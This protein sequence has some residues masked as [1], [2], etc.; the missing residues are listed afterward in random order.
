MSKREFTAPN[1]Y[2][3]NHS[4]NVRWLISHL[5]R[6]KLMVVATMVAGVVMT[7]TYT[8]SPVLIGQAAEEVMNP[9][10]Q[11]GM[12]ALLILG[13]LVLSGL[14]DLFHA[15]TIETLAQRLETGVREELYASLLGKSQTFH[16][17]QRVGDIMARATD[18]AQQLNGMVNPGLYF[19]FTTILG[20]AIPLFHISQLRA[21]LLLVPTIFVIAYVIVLRRYMHQLKPVTF[22]QRMQFGKMN[23]VAEETISGIEI[24][25]ASA[26]E[27]FERRKF[28][29]NARLFRGYFVRQGFIE[30]RYLPLLLL[31]IAT[32]FALL[33]AVVLYNA[34]SIGIAEI[35]AYMGLINVLR[36]PT[37]ISVFSF[38][39]VQMGLAS[40]HR[41]LNIIQTETEMD[42]NSGGYSKPLEGAI[43]FENVT[44]AYDE[45][46]VLEDISFSIRPGQTVAIVGQTGSGKSTLTQLINRTYDVKSG[47][48]LIDGVDV[49]DWDLSGLRSQISNIEQDIF[50]FSRSLSENI[51]FGRPEATQE[52]IERVSSEAQAHD[53]IQSFAQGYATEVGDRGVTL[54]G[55]QRQRIA[56]AR[57][58]LSDPR[59][60]ILDDSTSAIDSATED[61]IQKA[62][63]RA[64]EGRTTLL[65]THRL[66]QIR[67]A[68]H[69][70]VLDKGRLVASGSHDDLLRT[71][72]HY[73]RIF[74]R[75]DLDLPPLE[76][77]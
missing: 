25:K 10:G 55:G 6:H 1:A 48:I 61:S 37:F 38:S 7:Y 47:R 15:L 27:L 28:S 20:I 3:Y 30:A 45:Q 59:I 57:A 64:Q 14:A 18:D 72:T 74:A 44:F 31:G 58:F 17:R 35:V 49:R 16:D 32:G 9:T 42:E 77:A 70:L 19:I 68:D 8:Y 65:I 4:S 71:S 60:L 26:Q 69:I 41:I 24:V 2:P 62:I 29:R 46:N 22:K 23:A 13:V 53:F 76:A 56:L 11:L 75:Y 5:A 39:L 36:F 43:T 21:E 63:R 51:A 40:A 34:G 52:D 66:S 54:S 73:R 67:W 33:H 50:L 12:L